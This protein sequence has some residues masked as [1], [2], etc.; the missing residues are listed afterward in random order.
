MTGLKQKKCVPCEK[1]TPPLQE[2]A[3]VELTEELGGD[4]KVSNWHHLEKEYSFPDFKSGLAFVN[5]VGELAEQ[6]GHHPDIH[7]GWG[8]VRIVLWTHAINGL[9][10]NDFVLAAKCDEIQQ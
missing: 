3:I 7:L 8:K 10:E 9:S 6:E 5:K 1:G 2:E 4:W